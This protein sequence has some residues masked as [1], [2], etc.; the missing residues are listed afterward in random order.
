M[1]RFGLDCNKAMLRGSD[2]MNYF[3]EIEYGGHS[4]ILLQLLGRK[5][6]IPID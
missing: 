2:G 3:S 4:N 6:M 5:S 1:M